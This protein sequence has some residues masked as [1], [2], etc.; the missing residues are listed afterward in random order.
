MKFE[1]NCSESIYTFW[2]LATKRKTVINN[3]N[4]DLIKIICNKLYKSRNNDCWLGEKWIKYYIIKVEN[5]SDYYFSLFVNNCK[6][7]PIGRVSEAVNIMYK[8]LLNLERKDF[9]PP[10]YNINLDDIQIHKMQD[11]YISVV[12]YSISLHMIEIV[13]FIHFS[14]PQF[15][16]HMKL[17]YIEWNMDCAWNW[18]LMYILVPIKLFSHHK[19]TIK[20]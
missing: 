8:E 18:N 14:K 9:I 1:D 10:R 20:L 17:P 3:I 2:L 6:H 15:H 16:E 13:P 4:K 7:N 19:Y 12:N 11:V 5:N